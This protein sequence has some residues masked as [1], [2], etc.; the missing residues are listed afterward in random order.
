M[1][2]NYANA[3]RKFY[4]MVPL[5]LNQ[6]VVDLYQKAILNTA[7]FDTSCVEVHGLILVYGMNF[8]TNQIIFF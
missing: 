4:E 5:L 1:R 2:K 8:C 7:V 3:T 6:V